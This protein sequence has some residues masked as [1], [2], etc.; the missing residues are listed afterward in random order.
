[1]KLPHSSLLPDQQCLVAPVI[2]S[3]GS[4]PT[5]GRIRLRPLGRW[6]VVGLMPGGH[7]S[8]ALSSAY[9]TAQPSLR[10]PLGPPLLAVRLS[11]SA[12]ERIQNNTMES[13]P[14]RE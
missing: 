11:L 6:S 12:R 3:I 10:L 5:T 2:R 8:T 14:N 13:T 4:L 7:T 9:S 1:V